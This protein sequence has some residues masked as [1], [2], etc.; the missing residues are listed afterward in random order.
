MQTKS[1]VKYVRMSPLKVRRVLDQIR[2]MKAL[3]ATTALSFLPHASA[4]VINKILKS[5][6]ANAEH[7]HQVPAAQ[8]FVSECFVDQGPTLKRFQPH[9]QGRAFPIK[10]RT[11]H[12]TIVVSNSAKGDKE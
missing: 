9:A 8:L 3:E 12:I 2:G 7:N 6:I 4:R 10:K 11:S 1:S 5:A